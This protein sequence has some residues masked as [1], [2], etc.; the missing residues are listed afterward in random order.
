MT[1][2]PTSLRASSDRTSTPQGGQL[3]V[4]RDVLALERLLHVEAVAL[5]SNEM[6]RYF[7]EFTRTCSS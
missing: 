1:L 3:D 4:A 7:I 5:E 2:T 6:I